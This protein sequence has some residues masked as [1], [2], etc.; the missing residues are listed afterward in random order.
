[1]SVPVAYQKTFDHKEKVAR[2]IE[3]MKLAA[4]LSQR[5]YG[6]PP[7]VCYSGGKDSDVIVEL[8]RMSGVEFEVQ[9]SRTTADAPETMRHVREVFNS[10]K[11]EGIEC[12]YVNPTYKGEH[13][14]MWT[15]IPP[16][17]MPPTRLVR[18]C[19]RTLKETGGKGRAIVTGVRRAEST[20]RA[21]R[22][23]AN[24]FSKARPAALDF[25][26]AASLFEDADSAIEH[27]D[28]FLRSCRINGKTS[29]QPI[30]EW[31]DDD[32]WQFID[33]RGVAV[34]P[35]YA[36][37]FKRVGCIGCPFAGRKEREREFRRWPSYETAYK[38]A[39]A[40][41]LDARRERGLPTEWQTPEE[42]WEWW[43][44]R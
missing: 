44:S 23:F 2:S 10:L 17:L 12:S 24:N 3:Q 28:N 41:M 31:E 11:A 27:D 38:R 5:Y 8:A 6:K 19:C 9:H 1:M 34:N 32:V 26:D 15:L 22:K 13:V 20:A 33:E 7:L 37:G 21:S 40:R 25:E 16:K 18:Y 43:M 14:N 4:A 42:V 36:E 30:L 39:F 35:L 29:F